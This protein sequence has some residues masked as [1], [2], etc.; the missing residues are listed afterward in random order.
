ML[1]LL[2]AVLLVVGS[3]GPAAA[4]PAGPTDY[5]TT[6]ESVDPATPAISVRM[7]GGDSFFELTQLQPVHITVAGYG[8]EPYLRIRSNGVVEI[9]TL[10]PTFY[11][12]D[13]RYGAGDIVPDFAD[14]DAEPRWEAVGSGGRYAWHDHRSHWM[15][16]AQPPGAEPGDVILEDVIVIV[17]DG[18]RVAV[19]VQSTLQ[20][21]PSHVP[22]LV[23][24]IAGLACVL[25]SRHAGLLAVIPAVFGLVAGV[26]AVG[27]VPAETGPSFTLWAPPVIA[28]AALAAVAVVRRRD[29]NPLVEVG[30]T[31]VAAVQLVLWAVLGFDALTKPILPTDLPWGL[32]R[33]IVAASLAAGLALFITAVGKLDRTFRAP[34]GSAA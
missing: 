28:I 2:V 6:I 16:P 29:V 11:L 31:T 3:A 20:Q 22:A 21:R 33:A 10:S 25:L 4:D 8:A 14:P 12:N 34:L 23:G 26:V 5:L 18:Q 19:S 30:L 17:V 24:F 15:N 27:S 32:H 9:N 7:I 13:D 1:M